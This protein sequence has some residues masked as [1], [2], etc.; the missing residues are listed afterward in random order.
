[1]VHISSKFGSEGSQDSNHWHPKQHLNYCPKR[2]FSLSK[3]QPRFLILGFL[4][5][6]SL[7]EEEGFYSKKKKK[8]LELVLGSQTV[9]TIFKAVSGD[10]CD[11]CP[12]IATTVHNTWLLYH[13]NYKCWTELTMLWEIWC[14]KRK[15][16]I[17][18]NICFLE[19]AGRRTEANQ[20]AGTQNSKHQNSNP[21]KLTQS[22]EP[23]E[24]CDW[25]T[26]PPNL[27]ISWNLLLSRC[28]LR[29]KL[30]T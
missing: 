28:F 7:N 29:I 23:I 26:S 6:T 24:G 8:H 19:G 18:H 2:C 12:Y 22:K 30:V 14:E 27:K 3:P 21:I 25:Y 10:C 20:V 13:G 4:S 9:R 1:M 15:H 17:S 11:E 16:F 5:Q